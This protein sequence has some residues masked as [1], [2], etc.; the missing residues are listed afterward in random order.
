MNSKKRYLSIVSFV[1]SFVFIFSGLFF[2]VNSAHAYDYGNPGISKV[3][4]V[5]KISTYFTKRQVKKIAAQAD[6]FTD[7]LDYGG[8]I[9]GIKS[10]PLGGAALIASKGMNNIASDF[11]T[12]K[13]KGTG[14]EWSYTYTIYKDSNRGK[15]SKFRTS[16][17]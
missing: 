9:A 15:I 13:A 5:H 3:S 2:P 16:Y 10:L 1:A 4:S 7:A 14:L 17:R 11:R 12:A 8:F 6:N